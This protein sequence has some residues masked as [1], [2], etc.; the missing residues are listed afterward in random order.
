MQVTQPSEH[1]RLCPLLCNRIYKKME[2]IH[3][4]YASGYTWRSQESEAVSRFEKALDLIIGKSILHGCSIESWKWMSHTWVTWICIRST[5]SA[6]CDSVE[7]AF[8]VTQ[9]RQTIRGCNLDWNVYPNRLLYLGPLFR[10]PRKEISKL[11]F[12]NHLIFH[13]KFII[14]SYAIL[15]HKNI[16]RCSWVTSMYVSATE[17]TEC[18]F[19]SCD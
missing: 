8:F 12:R 10:V 9:L 11:R 4:H 17:S 18:G 7:W 3:W 19:C 14:H 15:S 1:M 5:E 13:G 6:E 2:K 16:C